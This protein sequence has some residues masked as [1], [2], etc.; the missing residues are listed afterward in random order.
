MKK[1]I[2]LISLLLVAATAVKAQAV[3]KYSNEFLNIGVGARGLGMGNS[4]VA[5]VEDVY[6]NYYNESD[7]PNNLLHLDLRDE[8]K[9]LL[10]G[11]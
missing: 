11:P 10:A 8:E 6:A 3:R 9:Q 5:T 7:N 1:A 4:Q 2:G